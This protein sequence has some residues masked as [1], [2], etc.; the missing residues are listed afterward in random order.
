MPQEQE[1]PRSVP[2]HWILRRADQVTVA[3]L[4]LSG[5]AATIGWWAVRGGWRGDL[6]EIDRADPVRARFEVD[7]NEASW[8]ELVQLPELG[9]TLARRIVESREQQGPFLDHDDLMRVNG[10]GPKTLDQLRPYL[11]PMPGGGDLA[12]GDVPG[13]ERL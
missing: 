10:I 12:G 13:E 3:V 2:P 5:V 8:P 4:V 6:V 7:L 9:E 11:R 1:I